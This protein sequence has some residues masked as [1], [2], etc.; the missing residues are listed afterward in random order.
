MAQKLGWKVGPY[1]YAR[2]FPLYPIKHRTYCTMRFLCFHSATCFFILFWFHW[3]M[4]RTFIQRIPVRLAIVNK[5]QFM[6]IVLDVMP[7]NLRNIELSMRDPWTERK[8]S[9]F[10][11]IVWSTGLV[12]ALSHLSTS[13]RSFHISN[14]RSA[15]SYQITSNW[16]Y[17][18]LWNIWFDSPAG[19]QEK[20]KKTKSSH[21][22]IFILN[23]ISRYE[24]MNIILYVAQ[25]LLWENGFSS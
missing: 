8:N 6:S 23:E 12:N 5:I 14:I 10:V 9:C 22:S 25:S 11:S 7:I 13:S 17:M 4:F 18:S 15:K 2:K 24:S 19:E 20:P 21:H 16:I 3:E 1:F